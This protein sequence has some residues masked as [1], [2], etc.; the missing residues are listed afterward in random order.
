MRLLRERPSHDRSTTIGIL[1]RVVDNA[2]TPARAERL[3]DEA[4]RARELTKASIDRGI[5]AQWKA[6][7]YELLDGPELS[8][9]LAGRLPLTPS[10]LVDLIACTCPMRRMQDVVDAMRLLVEPG[11]R[12]SRP[13][14]RF[15]LV[16]DAEGQLQVDKRMVG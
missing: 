7:G 14:H 3:R 12:R 2:I 1:Q 13:E 8:L 4:E 16:V 6:G 15:E 5:V 10:L 9:W 11:P